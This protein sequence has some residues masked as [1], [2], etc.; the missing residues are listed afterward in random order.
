[1]SFIVKFPSR[2]NAECFFNEMSKEQC[3]V[4]LSP[5][6][7]VVT[8]DDD[9]AGLA[10]DGEQAKALAKRLGGNVQESQ[11]YAPLA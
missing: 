2:E 4:Y 5:R 9:Q 8:Y 6:K 11:Q 1:M 7:P 10:G 3:I